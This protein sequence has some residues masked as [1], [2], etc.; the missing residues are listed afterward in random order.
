MTAFASE[1]RSERHVKYMPL[2]FRL[3]TSYIRASTTKYDD[4]NMFLHKAKWHGDFQWHG[5]L[6]E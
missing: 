1:M 5:A 6:T 3:N 2:G 4:A